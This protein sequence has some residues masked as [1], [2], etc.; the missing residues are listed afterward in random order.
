MHEQRTIKEWGDKEK[1]QFTVIK[2]N[3]ET[4]K[5]MFSGKKSYNCNW[6]IKR[7]QINRAEG[8]HTHLFLSPIDEWT[9]IK[10]L[11]Y[12]FENQ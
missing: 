3:L 5:V 4:N 9:S 11:Y 8:K 2:G 10:H 1:T 6:E 12:H 7:K